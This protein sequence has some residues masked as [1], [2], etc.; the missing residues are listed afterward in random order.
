MINV[1]GKENFCKIVGS[2]HELL[3]E[4]AYIAASFC[5]ESIKRLR[6]VAAPAAAKEA[7]SLLTAAIKVGCAAAL[8]YVGVTGE[9]ADDAE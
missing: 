1:N 5:K 3:E 7:E 8:A 2:G 9:D 4:V 6:D